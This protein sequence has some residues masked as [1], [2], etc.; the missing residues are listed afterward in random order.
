MLSYNYSESSG[1]REEK[2]NFEAVM[3][4]NTSN[5]ITVPG[6][7][8]VVQDKDQVSVWI[9]I[10]NYLVLTYLVLTKI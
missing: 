3:D 10:L 9:F 4:E 2:S 8:I 5:F 1:T 6:L 7:S